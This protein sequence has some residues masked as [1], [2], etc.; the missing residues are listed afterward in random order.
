MRRHLVDVIIL[1][2]LASGAAAYLAMSEPQWRD[3]VIR[4]YVFV[5]GALVML[6]LVTAAGDAFPRKRRSPFERALADPPR[7]AAKVPD[8]ERVEREVTLAIGSAHDLHTR[9]LPHLREIAQL[10]LARSGRR[11]DEHTAGEWWEL[12]RPDREPPEDKFASG[13]KLEDLRRCLDD[14]ARIR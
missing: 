4:A 2:V 12:L 9:L 14:L 11:L 8:L 13:I 10:R 7:P 6:V 3:T 1:G 5:I